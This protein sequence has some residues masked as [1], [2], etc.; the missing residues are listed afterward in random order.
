MKEIYETKTKE[1]KLH[2][3]FKILRDHKPMQ[4][5]K[6][7]IENIAAEMDDKDG[8]FIQ[9]FQTTGFLPR[10]WEIFLF[11]FLQE[12]GFAFI[13]DNPR[14]DFHITKNEK[15]FFIEASLSNEIEV[16]KFSRADIKKALETKDE[17]LE[18]DL[19]DHY[20]IRMGSVLYSKLCKKYWELD[21]VKDKP[22][23]LAI[24]PAHNYL[25]NF[26]PDAKIIEYLYGLSHKGE[27]NESGELILK[28]I[29]K[30]ESHSFEKKE[31]PSNFFSLPDTENISAVIFTNNADLHKFNRM[32]YQNGLSDECIIMERAGLAF[33]W[34]PNSPGKEFGQSIKPGDIQEDW[35]ESVTIFHNPNAKIPLDMDLFENIRQVYLNDEGRFDGPMPEFFVFHS[36]TIPVL[37]EK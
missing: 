7:M 34:T 20:I 32:G 23:V 36:K 11:K 3:L 30:I 16:A 37:I 22:L 31:I 19:I 25:A 2:P 29:E 14:P 26:L 10:I 4:P 5:A 33:D 35:N 15:Y 17:K 1:E 18:K 8:N 28:S 24:T 21:W 12:N 9:Q 6:L 13:Q 27:L